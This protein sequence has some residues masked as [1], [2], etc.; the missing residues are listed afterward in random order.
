MI[1][2]ED[3]LPDVRCRSR[4]EEDA[5]P[6]R[7]RSPNLSRYDSGKFILPRHCLEYHG[8]FVDQLLRLVVAVIYP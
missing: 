2:D 1:Y 7:C 6:D 5:A 3:N 4:R 8:M